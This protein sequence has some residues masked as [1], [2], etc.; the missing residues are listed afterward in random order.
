MLSCCFSFVCKACLELN[1]ECHVCATLFHKNE[2]ESL[3]ET[4]LNCGSN[5]VLAALVAANSEG[6]RQSEQDCSRCNVE[7]PFYFC[8]QCQVRLCSQCNVIMHSLGSFSTHEVRAMPSR[9]DNQHSKA[10]Y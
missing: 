2:G 7:A 3:P 8:V 10:P 1:S 4:A 6:S 5:K 9:D